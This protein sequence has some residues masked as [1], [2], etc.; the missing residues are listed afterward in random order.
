M[1]RV[2]RAQIDWGRLRAALDTRAGELASLLRSA[3]DA[4]ARVTGLEWTVAE[5]G[6]HLVT[7]PRRFERFG[8][9]QSEHVDTADIGAFNATENAGIGETS[10]S[11]LADLF[12]EAHAALVKLAAERDGDDPFIWFDLPTTWAQACGIYLGELVVHAVD[13]AR[14]TGRGWTVDRDDAL[15]VA[16]GLVPIL[17][18]FVDPD[19]A[20][21]FTGTFEL[22]LRG[23]API[24]MSF[25]AAALTVTRNG[26]R[27]DCK[28]SADP[29]AFLLVG[30]GRQSQWGPILRGKM[31]ASGRKPWLALRFNS[32][33]LN[34]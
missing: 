33:L 19:G 29:A 14:T 16:Y 4:D 3:P 12:E 15:D 13:L 18:A 24:T 1:A 30:Y 27:P 8:R 5:L 28:I 31:M 20:K 23:G 2:S 7:E 32:L 6:A 26:A 34:P 11:A 25:R 22:R 9:G 17:P 10:P 21:G